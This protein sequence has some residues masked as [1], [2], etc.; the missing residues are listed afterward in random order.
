MSLLVTMRA[1]LATSLAVLLLSA[2]ALAGPVTRGNVVLPEKRENVD[3]RL[4]PNVEVKS[5]TYREKVRGGEPSPDDGLPSSRRDTT[6]VF[7]KNGDLV[8]RK[9]V[10]VSPESFPDFFRE[11]HSETFD[12]ATGK[13]KTKVDFRAL[14][15][16]SFAG[17]T[18]SDLHFKVS[19][20]RPGKASHELELRIGREPS[21]PKGYLR[22]RVG[23]HE[24]R[25]GVEP[26]KN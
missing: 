14:A 2:S 18:V 6:L 21:Q 9:T 12:G 20:A 4:Y 25:L 5:Y 15:F 16:T 17:A 10:E 22:L 24:L 23:K 3:Q 7:D 1:P 13:S 26:P 8:K 11:S 19:K